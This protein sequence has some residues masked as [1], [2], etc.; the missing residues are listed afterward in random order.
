MRKS[1]SYC[2]A[3]GHRKNA[4]PKLKGTG[5]SKGGDKKAEVG[6]E[7]GGKVR[8]EEVEDAE[9]EEQALNKPKE[10]KRARGRA[11]AKAVEK[12]E[13]VLKPARS[14]TPTRVQAA[15]GQ[16]GRD[17]EADVLDK[18][19]VKTAT[20]SPPT[21][22][23]PSRRQNVDKK[24]TG[25]EVRQP[26]SMRC[27]GRGSRC[28]A[29]GDVPHPPRRMQQKLAPRWRQE[30]QKLCKRKVYRCTS[31]STWTPSTT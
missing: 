11:P 26:C 25:E 5:E 31:I 20:R 21:R 23:Q 18:E 6:R 29:K 13:Q 22:T 16:H 27:I 24:A 15:R 7:L 2:K 4:C 3:E 17:K 14:A 10:M 1:C 19:R 8:E 9:D 30:L 28:V 12:E